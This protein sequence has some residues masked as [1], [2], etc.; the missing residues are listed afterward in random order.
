[1]TKQ[2]R[3]QELFKIHFY[4][5]RSIIIN[6]P[7]YLT[8]CN[9]D[10]K[11]LKNSIR[12][13]TSTHSVFCNPPLKSQEILEC[14]HNRIAPLSQITFAYLIARPAAV[15]LSPNGQLDTNELSLRMPKVPTTRPELRLFARLI[16][17]R[18]Q[19]D[20]AGP[21]LFLL[22]FSYRSPRLFWLLNLN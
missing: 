11:Q 22:S 6:P 15:E 19:F 9:C 2:F 14:R 10:L 3:E 16:S 4:R 8:L 12:F 13:P 5:I 1:M 20:F 18:N 7:N 21:L 17:L